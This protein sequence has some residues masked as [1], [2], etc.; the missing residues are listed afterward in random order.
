MGSYVD[1]TFTLRNFFYIF[2][3][4]KFLCFLPMNKLNLIHGLRSECLLI[5]SIVSNQITLTQS[6]SDLCFATASCIAFK[7]FDSSGFLVN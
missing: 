3:V 6:V 7:Q 1:A 5:E 2:F 4:R